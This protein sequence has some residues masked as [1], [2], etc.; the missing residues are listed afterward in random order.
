MA[1]HFDVPLS[2]K[3]VEEGEYRTKNRPGERFRSVLGDRG[4]QPFTKITIV[5]ITHGKLTKDDDFA[6][7][8]VFELRFIA[9]GGRRFMSAEVIFRFE[10]SERQMIRDPVV[11]TISP[12]G[13]WA[14]NKTVKVQNVKHGA[15][16]SINAGIE[17]AGAEAGVSWEL[18]EIKTREFYTA[19]TGKKRV[20]EKT[21]GD[22][23]TAIWKLGENEERADGI[24]T[25]MRAAVLLRRPEDVPFTFRVDVRTDVDFIG[26]VKTL[27]GWEKRDP[28]DPVEIDP[29]R[30]PK[31]SVPAV[32]AQDPKI[33]N[34]EEMGTWDVKEVADV[35]VVT[36]SEES[37]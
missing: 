36:L 30:F 15:N 24:P 14:I 35:S 1:D 19:L 18:E 21:Y 27:F 8:L 5:S 16:A 12:Y 26:E 23:N 3:T 13:K 37:F 10:D 33:Y 28:I 20:M 17:L 32:K 7:L 31:A 25:F 11:H 34:L 29:G 22:D 2:E 4:N 6:T 9:T